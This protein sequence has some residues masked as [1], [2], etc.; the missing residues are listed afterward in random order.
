MSGGHLHSGRGTR[1]AVALVVLAGCSA[2]HRLNPPYPT[3]LP[4]EQRV[5]VWRGG[6]R[7]V[8]HH[9]TIDSATVQGVALPWRPNCDSC[10]VAIPVAQA[11]S[12]VLEN[13]DA[14]GFLRGT[15]IL[16]VVLLVLLRVIG[17]PAGTA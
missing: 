4:P 6:Q 5:Q 9:V 3:A 10:R 14:V 17:V 13:L 11:D 2:R 7:T 16:F 12:L 1:L 8:L 15:V